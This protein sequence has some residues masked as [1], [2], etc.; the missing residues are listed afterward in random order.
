MALAGQTC[1]MTKR[2][3]KRSSPGP[4]NARRRAVSPRPASV[5]EPDG[6]LPFDPV[7]E[8]APVEQSVG[9]E[10]PTERGAPVE[11]QRRA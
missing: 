5:E 1:I 2:K 3:P 4:V 8:K 9:F 10:P 11:P 6:V 7:L